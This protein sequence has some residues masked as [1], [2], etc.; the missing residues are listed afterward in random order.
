MEG[1]VLLFLEMGLLGKYKCHTHLAGSRG[2]CVISR[3]GLFTTVVNFVLYNLF[4]SAITVLYK[5]YY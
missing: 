4:F 5:V 2:D 3:A 1:K